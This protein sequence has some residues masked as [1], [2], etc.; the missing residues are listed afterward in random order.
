MNCFLCFGA[1][2]PRMAISARRATEREEKMLKKVENDPFDIYLEI[3]KKPDFSKHLNSETKELFDR[4][5]IVED[6]P[7]DLHLSK[8]NGLGT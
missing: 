1:E 3:L 2:N 6:D 5:M 7:F 8:I 4:V